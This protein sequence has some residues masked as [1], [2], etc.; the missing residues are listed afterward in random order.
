[1]K[2]LELIRKKTRY[3]RKKYII[4]KCIEKIG[5]HDERLRLR[6]ER[7]DSIKGIKRTQIQSLV[8]SWK[9]KEIKPPTNEEYYNFF[10]EAPLTSS[11]ID[12]IRRKYWED[13]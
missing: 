5:G 4:K 2:L 9:L 8:T 6:R 1:M 3:L 12:S 11:Y 7:I 10:F 13:H